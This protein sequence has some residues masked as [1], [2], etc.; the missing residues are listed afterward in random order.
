MKG[1]LVHKVVWPFTLI[2]VAG[3]IVL[4]TL[5]HLHLSA[6]AD[7]NLKVRVETNADFL[8]STAFPPSAL[9]ANNLGRMLQLR[10]V[11]RWEGRLITD[12][13]PLS[14]E[15]TAFL[16]ELQA[17][18]MVRPVPQSFRAVAMTVDDRFDLIGLQPA[19][20]LSAY[21]RRKEVLLSLFLFWGLSAAFALAV[22][23]NLVRPLQ[24]LTRAL[25]D[26]NTP[27][28]SPELPGAQRSDEIGHLARTFLDTHQRLLKETVAREQ[29]ERMAALARVTTGLA[30]EIRNPLA[31]I[32]M[33]T[34]LLPENSSTPSILHATAQIDSLVNQWLFLARPE[35]PTRS[36]ASVRETVDTSC[37]L[38][39]AHARQQDVQI[40]NRIAPELKWSFD[41]RRMEQVFGNLILNAVQA[42]PEGGRLT[43]TARADNGPLRVDFEDTGMGFSI[44]ALARFSELFYSEKEGGMGVGLAVAREIVAAHGGRLTARNGSPAGAIVTVEIP[45]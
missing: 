32:R 18:G 9:L 8:H 25:P 2:T 20:S 43:I 10:I 22:I 5:F 17:D 4:L 35:P 39:E 13:N 12:G 26:I 19:E 31:A 28:A 7:R 21:F 36:T 44:A 42:M 23:R 24:A 34:Q 41:R 14:K 11:F 40:D 37:R 6:Q 38:M 29:A 45:S 15:L 27:S 3:S 30:H 16:S 1:M 33:H